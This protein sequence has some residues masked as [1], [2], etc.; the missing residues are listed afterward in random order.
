[1]M[2]Q[3]NGHALNSSDRKN[4]DDYYAKMPDQELAEFLRRVEERVY[5]YAGDVVD[6]WLGMAEQ[7]SQARGKMLLRGPKSEWGPWVSARFAGFIGI[8]NA[9]RLADLGER[10]REELMELRSTFT[11]NSGVF[12]IATYLS[13]PEDIQEKVKSGEVKATGNDIL[14]AVKEAEEAKRRAE[15][16]R[17]I[18]TRKGVKPGKILDHMSATELAMNFLRITQTDE[19]LRTREIA[20]RDAANET[21][22]RVGQ[23]VRLAVERI[24]GTMPEELPTPAQSIQQIEQAEQKRVK[25]EL[26]PSLFPD[27]T[28]EDEE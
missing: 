7:F 28:G 26:Q 22:Y 19:Q 10:S 13:A 16:A 14:K 11:R 25:G 3:S 24:G 17:A 12:A 2:T 18:A 23:E 8:A 21:H 1:M 20:D 27:D 6:G 5:S 9:N 4:S 15:D